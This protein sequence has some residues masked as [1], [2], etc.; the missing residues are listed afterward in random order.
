LYPRHE[1]EEALQRVGQ[2]KKWREED[3]K[4]G[5]ERIGGQDAAWWK[6]GSQEYRCLRRRKLKLI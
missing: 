2:G 1:F 4:D 5:V 6:E 3:A